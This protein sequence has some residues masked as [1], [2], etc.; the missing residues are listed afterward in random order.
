MVNKKIIKTK[1][2]ESKIINKSSKKEVK[3]L[4]YKTTADI[5]IPKNIATHPAI[6]WANNLT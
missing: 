4:N 5:L 6:I 2:T 3:L 1:T